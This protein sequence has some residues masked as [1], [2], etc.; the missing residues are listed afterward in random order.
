[1]ERWLKRMW[2]YKIISSWR[3]RERE[4]ENWPGG[5]GERNGLDRDF[6]SFRAIVNDKHVLSAVCVVSL[7]VSRS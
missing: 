5:G 3:E 4:R 6:S 2:E 1:L 7:N